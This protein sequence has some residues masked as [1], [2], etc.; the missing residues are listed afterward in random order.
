MTAVRS[1]PLSPGDARIAAAVDASLVPA[2][3]PIVA[4]MVGY[5]ATL[6]DG[7]RF[8]FSAVSLASALE[9]SAR[10]GLGPVAC[11]QSLAEHEA[12]ERVAIC[13]A[14]AWRRLTVGA[15]S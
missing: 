6:A 3:P 14:Y 15:A 2:L 13:G 1:F 11:V 5:V 12:R 10:W 4:P 8:R 7:R 9:R